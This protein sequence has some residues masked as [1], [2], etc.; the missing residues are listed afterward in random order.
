MHAMSG[1]YGRG[2]SERRWSRRT[3]L[4][5]AGLVALGAA[6]A[7]AMAAKAPVGGTAVPAEP[8]RDPSGGRLFR[9]EQARVNPDGAAEVTAQTVDGQL[10][11]PE[12]RF[13][14]GELLRILLQ[15]A[16]PSEP[17]TV[18][19]HGLLLPAAMDGVPDISQPPVAPGEFFVYEFPLVQS[20]TYWYHSHYELQEQRGLAGALIIE[21]KDEA[22]A[23]DRDYVLFLADWLHSDPAAIIP[24]LRRAAGGMKDSG[25]NMQPGGDGSAKSM[26]ADAAPDLSDV[27]YDAFLLN[28][29]GPADPWT[30]TAKA[31][32][33]IRFRLINGAAST[34]F[35]FGIDAHP[36]TLTHA[37]GQPVAPVEVDQ[38]LIGM[39]ECYD[40]LVPVTEAGSFTIRAEAQDGSGQA[41]GIVRTPEAPARANMNR[42][43]WQGR[44][45]AYG[46][47]RARRP[48]ELPP[49]MRSFTLPLEGRMADYV[50]LIE[51]A[52][53]PQADPLIIAP[54]EQVLVEMTN[55]TRMWHPMHLHGHFFRL[56][57]PGVD[58]RLAP[59]KHTVNVAPGETVRLQ[60]VADNPGRWF[61]H[62]HNLYHLLAG[63]AREWIYRV[64][65]GGS[66][67]GGQ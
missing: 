30:C 56:L 28:G 25:M 21:A 7:A 23:Y 1:G 62:C 54:G 10:P 65:V 48:T 26:P 31:G 15:N 29:R 67:G 24:G 66:A 22:G 45:L 64:P 51:G 11:G 55:R 3:L 60:F 34:T 37:D 40:F 59:S 20:G 2:A 57:A 13:R 14:E 46:Q 52:A 50:W 17:T 33:R 32:E 47:L 6:P 41:I 58:P 19:W 44:T 5:G 49:Q 39:G 9:I 61:F 43:S 35:R 53:W 36:L 38:L 63:M 27:K 4:K 42:P 12:L 16:L 8:R 18:H